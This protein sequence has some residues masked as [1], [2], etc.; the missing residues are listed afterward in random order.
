MSSLSFKSF[1]KKKKK[2]SSSSNPPPVAEITGNIN[3]DNESVE[4]AIF[5]SSSELSSS[6]SRD[7][8]PTTSPYTD[9]QLENNNNNIATTANEENTRHNNDRR[10]SFDSSARTL[11]DDNISSINTLIPGYESTYTRTLGGDRNNRNNNRG[12]RGNT[13][14]NGWFYDEEHARNLPIYASRFKS[15]T[16]VFESDLAAKVSHTLTKKQPP[17]QTTPSGSNNSNIECP[18]QNALS[19][20]KSKGKGKSTSGR[21]F[22]PLFSGNSASSTSNQKSNNNNKNILSRK[23]STPDILVA[24]SNNSS[25]KTNS[26]NKNKASTSEQNTNNAIPTPPSLFAQPHG[27]Y[28]PF[29]RSSQPFMTIYKIGSPKASTTS[30]Q[31]LLSDVVLEREIELGLTLPP[32]NSSVPPYN[33]SNSN[34]SNSNNN[35]NNALQS[36]INTS[37]NEK[38]PLCKVWQHILPGSV[39]KVKYVIEFEPSVLE[40]SADH[41][42]NREGERFI[43]RPQQETITMINDGSNRTT[44][45]YYNGQR[46]RWYGTTGLAST[47]GSGYFELRIVENPNNNNNNNNNNNSTNITNSSQRPGLPG[48]TASESSTASSTLKNI[49][50]IDRRRPPIALYHNVAAKPFESLRHRN[51]KVGE[52]TIWEPGY[53]YADIIVIMGLVLR[54][55]EERK[56]VEYQHVVENKMFF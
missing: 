28:L 40:S 25:N 13:N 36:S 52:F 26:E 45:T 47:F 6:S 38:V 32:N 12:S 29:T 48:R 15:G 11:L 1:L 30:G 23:Q 42:L 46:M 7:S 10:S 31:I 18:S 8:I 9:Q 5:S 44:E 41:D 3:N 49:H 55:Q 39:D 19:P 21:R 4:H 17:V 51:R 2:S 34:N 53:A 37:N 14:T 56:D 33:N 54:E 20:S 22:P 43:Y 50:E 16:Q 24:A 27:A 35:S